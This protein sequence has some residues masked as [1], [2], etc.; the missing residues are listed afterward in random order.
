MTRAPVLL[1]SLL[2]TI[3]FAL[4]SAAGAQVPLPGGRQPFTATLSNLEPLV[5]G[6][7]IG[8]ASAALGQKPRYLSGPPGNEI[9]LALRDLGGSG[10]IGHHDRLYLQFRRGKLAGWKEDYDENWMWR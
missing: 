2:T 4:S 8:Q 7:D 10:L 5:F 9:Y 1:A 6:M 3:V